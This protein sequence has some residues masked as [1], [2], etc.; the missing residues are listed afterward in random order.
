MSN[1]VGTSMR[2]DLIQPF[3]LEATGI[4][5]RLVRTGPAI[6]TILARH[7]YPPV[8][9]ELLAEV[10]T[11]TAVLS[12]LMKFDGCFTLQSKSDGPV[13]MLVSD[14]TSEGVLRGYAGINEETLAQ[15]L[16]RTEDPATLTLKDLTG[17]GYLAFTVDQGEHMERY[18]GIVELEG[19]TLSECI[20]GYFKQ[21]DQIKT[22]VLVKT[23]NKEGIWRSGG[24]ILQYMPGEGGVQ[25]K[26]DQDE[27]TLREDWQRSMVL[28]ASCTAGELLD[29]DLPV[30]DLLYRLFHEE[31]VRVFDQKA[32][33]EGCRCSREKLETVIKT[34]PLEEIETYKVEGKI[35][36]SC[37]FCSR[38]YDFDD[39][40]LARLNSGAETET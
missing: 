25:G 24:M 15:L 40:D 29:L 2:D 38:S 34:I 7:D 39:A 35:V 1:T 36:A 10:L 16:E 9:N 6:S 28:M 30:T 37:E 8:V 4:R 20:Q 23:E 11:L 17:K 12:S 27:E 3:L 32:I 31:E 18:Q 5:G 14:M 33:L 19:A 13:K 21:S 22:G 26:K